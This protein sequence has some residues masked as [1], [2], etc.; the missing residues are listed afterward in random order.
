LIDGRG[1]KRVIWV[2]KKRF[3]EVPNKNLSRETRNL[4]VEKDKGM[5]E[6]ED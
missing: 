1:A 6:K 4:I 5:L 2:T 3:K